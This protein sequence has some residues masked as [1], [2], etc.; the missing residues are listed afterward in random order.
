MIFSE[1][2]LFL[3][4]PKTGGMTVTEILFSLLRPPVYYTQPEPLENQQDGFIHVAG[5]RHETLSEAQQL[6]PQYGY[7]V[8]RCPLIITGIRNPYDLEVSRYA[9]LRRDHCWDRGWNQALALSSS[10]EEFV[11]LSNGHGGAE[12]PL[13]AYY[14]LEGHQPDNLRLL[15]FESLAADLRDLLADVGLKFEGDIPIVN[16]TEHLPFESYYTATAEEAVYERYRWV[17]DRG[18]YSRLPPRS[19]TPAASRGD[20]RSSAEAPV[21]SAWARLSRVLLECL[22]EGDDD[23]VLDGHSLLLEARPGVILSPRAFQR[24]EERG[25]HVTPVHF[26]SPIPDTRGLDDAVWETPSNMSGLRLSTEDQLKFLTGVVQGLE[27]EL[28]ELTHMATHAEESAG[29]AMQNGVFGGMDALVMYAILRSLKPSLV[30]EVGGGHSSRLIAAALEGNGL[31]ALT[32][33]EPYPS[34]VLLLDPPAAL[35]LKRQDVQSTRISDFKVMRAG[36]VLTIDSSHVARIG[37]DVNY[38][39][40]EVLPVLAKGV[41]VHFHDVF[42]PFDYPK[43]WIKEQHRFWNEQYLLQA[44]LALNDSYEVLCCN[45]FLGANRHHRL[46]EILP[47]SPWWGGGSIWIRRVR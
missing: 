14:L 31:G 21:D 23:A 10:F 18:L 1:E 22:D 8:P 4:V 3:H 20:D 6:L 45:S 47:M 33:I 26:Y 7:S 11:C 39:I 13:D 19:S 2:L 9:Y 17:F 24:F 12:R 30:V 38:L 28:T 27:G 16:R 41:V 35:E 44:F 32:V 42:F 37:S 46:R 40:L 29:F 5:I 25:V 43:Q 36:D 34:E 15:R